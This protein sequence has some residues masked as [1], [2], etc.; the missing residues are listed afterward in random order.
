MKP[1]IVFLLVLSQVAA[2]QPTYGKVSGTIESSEVVLKWTTSYEDQTIR[3]SVWMTG[4]GLRW[5]AI[6]F[7]DHGKFNNSDFCLFRNGKLRDYYTDNDFILHQDMNQDCELISFGRPLSENVINSEVPRRVFE[8]RRRFSTCDPR[9]YA[10]EP[11]TTQF[12]FTGGNVFSKNLNDAK[13]SLHFGQ[14]INGDSEIPKMEVDRSQFRVL[15]DQALIPGVVTSYWCTVKKVP[16]YVQSRKHH[17]IMM[18]SV[19]Q[20]ENKHIV[21][22]MVIYACQTN[23]QTEFSLNCNDPFKPKSSST[24]SRVVGA[25]SMGEGSVSYPP[26]AGLPIGGSQGSSYLMVEIH[27]N[28][29]EKVTGVRDSSGFQFVVTPQLRLFDAGIMELGLIYSDAN[30]IPPQQDA[31]PITGYC[32]EDCTKKLPTEGIQVFASQLHAHLTGRKLWTSHYRNGVKVGELNRDNHYSPHWQ[33]VQQVRPYVHVKQGD[34]LA[35]TCVYETRD[36]SSM[37]LGGYG[38]EDEMC[39]NYIYYFPVSEIEVCKSAVDNSS[40]HSYFAHK[41]KIQ[42]VELPI[43]LKY[44]SIDWTEEKSLSLKELY[45]SAPLN[46][47]CLQHDGTLFSGHNWSSIPVPRINAGPFV[48]MRDVYE[49]PSL[50][51]Y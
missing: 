39:V 38:I 42:N 48:K 49:C 20:P 43:H 2:S 51:D 23:D 45:S 28:N 24:C 6:G 11:G 16:E 7:S 26:E 4:P 34:V 36:R 50:N 13:K 41:H 18:N 3:F 19:V 27:Y 32:V 47:H 15:A 17:V 10:F 5:M 35:T 29:V 25:W 8:F 30:S 31:F 21:H 12:I 22:H 37:T 1:L 14:V 33:H 44:N 40:L 46:M 9:D